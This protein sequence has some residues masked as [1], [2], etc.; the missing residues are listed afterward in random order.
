M[1]L[2]GPCRWP[3]GCRGVAL[4]GQKGCPKHA[5]QLRTLRNQAQD[6]HR[7][8]STG[9]GYGRAWQRLRLTVLADAPFC[10]CG[11]CTSCRLQMRG[12]RASPSACI[13]ASTEVDHVKPLRAGGTDDPANLQALCKSCHSAKTISETF[14]KEKAGRVENSRGRAVDRGSVK[15]VR[16]QN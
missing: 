3:T 11:G 7:P 1:K 5:E 15:R 12:L 4:P 10:R 9:R 6:K 14:S 2:S 8:S 16:R 13:R